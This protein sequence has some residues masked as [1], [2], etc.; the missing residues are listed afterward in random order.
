MVHTE[1]IT[2]D[3]LRGLDVF[4]GLHA[5]TLERLLRVGKVRHMPPRER[6]SYGLR[7]VGRHYYF[8]LR[9]VVVIAL[10]PDEPMLLVE[11]SGGKRPPKHQRFLGY[12]E[13]G[14]CFSDAYLEQQRQARPSGLACVAAN[15]VSLLELEQAHLRDLLASEPLWRD[16]LAEVVASERQLFLDRQD[17][18]RRVVQDFFLRENYVTSSVVRVGRSH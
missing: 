13:A 6:L 16:Q 8:L 2:S 15:A 9:G 12:F 10:D 11:I 5:V 14:A 7:G 18:T 1:H 3:H 17:P 4:R